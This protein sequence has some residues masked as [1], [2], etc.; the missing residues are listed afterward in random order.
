MS[1]E[2]DS[3]GDLPSGAC[4]A[5]H[6]C[7]SPLPTAVE[8][9]RHR[10]QRIPSG[11][12]R[13]VVLPESRIRRNQTQISQPGP[14][15]SAPVGHVRGVIPSFV[16]GCSERHW[17]PPCCYEPSRQQQQLQLTHSI[18][19]RRGS[20]PECISARTYPLPVW[21]C[22]KRG[23]GQGLRHG[24]HTVR[25]PS[26]ALDPAHRRRPRES[27]EQDSCCLPTPAHHPKIPR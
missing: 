23:P 3:S 21:I 19:S 7:R 24:W 18:I 12:G 6:G 20:N 8:V 5:F 15:F 13:P 2:A 9:V 26:A 17:P 16:V 11:L 4:P 27:T 22:A 1:G 25:I 10:P 14:H